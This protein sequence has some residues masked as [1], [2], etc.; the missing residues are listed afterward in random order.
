MFAL[1]DSDK[2]TY[3]QHSN[4]PQAASSC[5]IMNSHRDGELSESVVLL[6]ARNKVNTSP[7]TW[8][9]NGAAEHTAAHTTAN[10]WRI[11]AYATIKL[12]KNHKP[13]WSQM[14]SPFGGVQLQS[15]PYSERALSLDKTVIFYPLNY[16]GY[17]VQI[18]IALSEE[19]FW[20]HEW[21]IWI[22]FHKLFSNGTSHVHLNVGNVPDKPFVLKYFHFL[23]MRFNYPIWWGIK[24]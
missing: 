9:S 20:C 5:L 7:Y 3:G 10:V 1:R 11:T 24:T 23:I 13:G 17:L 8:W 22:V 4:H 14:V 12:W 6:E 15:F 16:M 2:L 19:T 21:N 18:R